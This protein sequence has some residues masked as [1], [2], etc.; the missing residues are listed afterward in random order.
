M[1]IFGKIGRSFNVGGVKVDTVLDSHQIDCF[2]SITGTV[3]MVGGSYPQTING[4]KVSLETTGKHGDMIHNISLAEIS[5]YESFEL[6]PGQVHSI[7][8][9][10]ELPGNTPVSPTIRGRSYTSNLTKVNVKTEIE[11]PGL[12][13]TDVDPITVIARPEH[14]AVLEGMVEAG[15]VLREMDVE[16]FYQAGTFA[17]EFELRPG[18]GWTDIEEIEVVFEPFEDVLRVHFKTEKI[19]SYHESNQYLDVEWTADAHSIKQAVR[20]FVDSKW[21]NTYRY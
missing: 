11:I 20:D 17:Q 8:F 15:M 1:S 4:I 21:R 7:P 19:W 6:Q 10:L 18:G 16:Y 3:N 9:T 14:N 13:A 2:G 5:Q 12:N